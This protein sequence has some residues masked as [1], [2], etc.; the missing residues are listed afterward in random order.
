MGLW[1]NLFS[2]VSLKSREQDETRELYNRVYETHINSRYGDEERA[3]EYRLNLFYRFENKIPEGLRAEF[4]G[5]YSWLL[6]SEEIIFDMPEMHG[7]LTLEQQ[8]ELREAL[9]RKLS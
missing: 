7:G 9:R 4:Y 3:K 5:P 2:S 6:M 8:V 1:A